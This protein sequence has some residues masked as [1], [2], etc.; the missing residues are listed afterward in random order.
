MA[1][2]VLENCDITPTIKFR[3]LLTIGTPNMG[4]SEI[5]KAGCTKLSMTKE[6]GALCAGQ[7]SFFIKMVYTEFMQQN[8]VNQRSTH[9]VSNN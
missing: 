4:V 3:N 9:V 7:N 5:P 6:G 1:R 2:S 8:L